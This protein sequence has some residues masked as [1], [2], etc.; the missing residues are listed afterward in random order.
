MKYTTV[1]AKNL[2]KEL[3]AE[4]KVDPKHKYFVLGLNFKN[5]KCLVS[6]CETFKQAEEYADTMN[7]NTK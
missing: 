2:E 5:V 3:D 4:C 1:C 6:S 7:K